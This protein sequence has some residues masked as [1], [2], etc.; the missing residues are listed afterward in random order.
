[1]IRHLA[2]AI[3]D[4]WARLHPRPAEPCL[5]SSRSASAAPVSITGEAGP[6]IA[7]SA[8]MQAEHAG[9]R[10]KWSASPDQ[11]DVR[12]SHT[13]RSGCPQGYEASRSPQTDRSC[14]E[15]HTE[16]DTSRVIINYSI[17]GTRRVP[18]DPLPRLKPEKKR[19]RTKGGLCFAVGT[20]R[21]RQSMAAGGEPPAAIDCRSH[22]PRRDLCCLLVQISAPASAKPVTGI[23]SI[24]HW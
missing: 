8:L 9:P 17:R 4:T 24:R 12:V 7:W 11:G 23:R 16:R 14:A 22:H 1:M 3:S 6:V 20:H 13:Y 15:K 10:R 2:R 21:T 5:Q 19:P 18:A